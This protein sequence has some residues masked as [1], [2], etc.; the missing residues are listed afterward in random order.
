M[1]RCCRFTSI[2]A[3]PMAAINPIARNQIEDPGPFEDPAPPAAVG[4]G[5]AG[6]GVGVGVGVAFGAGVGVG[7]AAGATTA[8]V[9][10]PA[11]HDWICWFGTMPRR[12]SSG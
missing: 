12:M 4:G 11:T 5:V 10:W 2:N 7:S 9:A 3:P 1:R 6:R 8:R